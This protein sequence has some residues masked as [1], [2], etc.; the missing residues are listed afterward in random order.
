[1]SL[2]FNSF[3]WYTVNDRHVCP[4]CKDR[5]DT[6]YLRRN[7]PTIPQPNCTSEN[8]CRCYLQPIVL[9]ALEDEEIRALNWYYPEDRNIARQIANPP[10][11][12][13][14]PKNP[15]FWERILGR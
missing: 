8:G 4:A 3:R 15:S 2:N 12:P 5:H 10:D 7:A 13:K 1:M 11:P 14:P 9:E 6:A